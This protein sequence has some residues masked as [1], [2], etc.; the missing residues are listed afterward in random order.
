MKKGKKKRK[1]I[2]SRDILNAFSSW[3]G[4]AYWRRLLQGF[5][6]L[7]ICQSIQKI[8]SQLV[9]VLI[10]LGQELWQAVNHTGQKKHQLLTPTEGTF[11]VPQQQLSQN[12]LHNDC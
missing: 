6:V 1:N 10:R 3:T 4:F 11:T 5:G 7:S 12:N 2:F 8:V 9:H